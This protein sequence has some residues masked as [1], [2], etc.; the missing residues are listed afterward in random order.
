MS[1]LVAQ[2]RFVGGQAGRLV[3]HRRRSL[4]VA[5][6]RL[7]LVALFFALLATAALA[8][9]AWVGMVQSGPTTV[10]MAEA[11]LPPRGEITDRNGVPLARAFPAYA[12]WFNPHPAANWR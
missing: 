7:L 10:S 12:L 9:I 6:L 4:L 3:D 11:L 1:T 5:R 2:H 8:R